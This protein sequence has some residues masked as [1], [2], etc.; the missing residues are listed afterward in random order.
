[1]ISLLS[2]KK[3]TASQRELLLN[4]KAQLVEYNA[5]AIN[6]LDFEIPVTIE[7]AIFTSQNAVIAFLN[8]VND[9]E[10]LSTMICF[11]VGEKTASLLI[12]KGIK[13]VKTA[14]NSKEL[15]L[16]ITKS[17]RK[18]NFQYFC[19]MER[20]EELPALLTNEEVAFLEV[21]TYQTELKPRKFDQKWDGILFFS[22]SAVLSHIS[23]NEIEFIPAFCIGETTAAEAKKYSRNVI[24]ANATN[25]ESVIA[26]A[27][28]VL[29]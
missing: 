5:I 2:T 23:K 8:K 22:P 17:H 27:V 24:V 3:L 4:A 14:K 28:K 1:M 12:E 18:S 16:Y 13:V 26:K 21:K 15:G 25:I 7:R 9:P 29:T 19:G 11:C 10:I 20:R 6:Y